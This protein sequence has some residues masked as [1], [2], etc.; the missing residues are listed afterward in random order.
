MSLDALYQEIILD[1]FK[2]PRNFGKLDGPATGVH[3]ENPSCGDQLDLQ[4]V[5]DEQDRIG[6]I[7]FYGRGCAISQSSASMM[8]ELVKGKTVAEARDAI[9]SFK[10]MLTGEGEAEVDLGNL[11]AL[12]G[13][14]QFP[15]RVKCATLAWKALESCL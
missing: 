7:K 2:N 13:V 11:E 6:K 5:I 12:S 14:K 1:H 15:V 4:V 9:A 8:T 3:H 10:H